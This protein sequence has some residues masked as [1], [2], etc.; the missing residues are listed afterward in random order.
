MVKEE[1]DFKKEFEEFARKIKEEN[2][3]IFKDD[4]LN[5]DDFDNMINL[6]SDKFSLKNE[7]GEIL[8][9]KIEIIEIDM[10]K[11]KEALKG[12][13][14]MILDVEGQGDMQR[15]TTYAGKNGKVREQLGKDLNSINAAGIPLDIRYK[16]GM[17]ALGLK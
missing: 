2:N 11:A 15:A 6:K 3:P 4:N 14:A 5:F 13:A 8:S 17:E 1:K 7:S 12:W 10:E 16:Q 9:K